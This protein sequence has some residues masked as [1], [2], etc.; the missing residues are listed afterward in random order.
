[1]K[2]QKPLPKKQRQ[3]IKFALLVIL[4]KLTEQK[5]KK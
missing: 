5:E 1:M 3:E 4:G 2:K